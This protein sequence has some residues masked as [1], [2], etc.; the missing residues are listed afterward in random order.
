MYLFEKIKLYTDSDVNDTAESEWTI[1]KSSESLSKNKKKQD[2]TKS[3]NSNCSTEKEAQNLLDAEIDSDSEH[4]LVIDTDVSDSEKLKNASPTKN[5]DRWL[6]S[7]TLQ[8]RQ[9]SNQNESPKSKQPTEKNSENSKSTSST[10]PATSKNADK[11]EKSISNKES[12]VKEGTNVAHKTVPPPVRYE[13]H[14]KPNSVKIVATELSESS[15][16]AQNSQVPSN[17]SKKQVEKSNKA[18]YGQESSFL[19]KR[20]EFS[21]Q[22]RGA[23]MN[24][25]LKTKLL[26]EK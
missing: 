16:T 13:I 8:I 10:K 22:Q 1:E 4:D 25:Q 6:L 20:S 18:K 12:N 23:A 15:Q 21:R 24:S 2:S 19:T 11:A 17:H 9:F 3:I 14:R 7:P 26:S 5:F